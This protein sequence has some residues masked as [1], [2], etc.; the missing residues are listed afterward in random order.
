[1][2]SSKLMTTKQ[3][4]VYLKMDEQSVSKLIHSGQIQAKKIG[5]Q[6][7]VNKEALN[8]NLGMQ[9]GELHSDILASL[10]K[11]NKKAVIKIMPLLKAENVIFNFSPFNKNQ[12][13]KALINTAVRNKGITPK[14]GEKLLYAVIE[15]ERLCSTAIG[16]GVAIPHPRYA[17]TTKLKKPLIILG[18]CKNGMDFESIDGRPTQLIFLISAPND[19]THLKLLARLSRLLRDKRFRYKLAMAGNFKEIKNIIEEKEKIV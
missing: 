19:N 11:N 7:Q 9:I 16:E 1:M 8:E 3:I 18:I 4:A 12:A 13:L 2:D 5:R 15:R 6:W 10:E 17:V 14:Q